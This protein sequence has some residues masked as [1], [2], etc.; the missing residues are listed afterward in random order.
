VAELKST[1]VELQPTVKRIGLDQSEVTILVLPIPSLGAAARLVV[2]AGPFTPGFGGDESNRVQQFISAVVAA[3]DRARLLDELRAANV[4]LQESDKHKSVFLANMSHELRTP[5]NAILGFSELLIDS[6]NGQYPV[7]TR[8]RFLEQINSSGRHLLGLIN[9]ILDLSK[10]EAGQMELRLQVAAVAEVV[11]DVVRTVEPL[12]ANKTIH[13]QVETDGAGDIEADA[14]KLKQMVLNLVSNA[15]KFTPEHGVVTIKASRQK[16]AVEVS[17]ADTGIGI[18]D[19]DRAR[20]FEAFQQLDSGVDRR[21][22]GTGLGLALTRR[23]AR[24]HG[25]DVRVASDVGKGSVFTI[26]LPLH[27]HRESADGQ[28][29]SPVSAGVGDP[30]RPLV[31]IVEDNSAAIELMSRNLERGGFRTVVARTGTEAIASA[32][33][34]QP[35][36]ITL[37]ILLPELDGWEVLTRLKHDPATS[38]IPVVVV[39]VVDN[40]EL[41]MA[42]GALDY[43][44]KPI[45]GAAFLKSLSRFNFRRALGR[46]EFRVLVVDDEPGNLEML[47]GILEPAGFTVIAAAGGREAIEL[48]TQR[49]PDLILLDLIMPDVTGFDVVEALRANQSTH[50]TP[51]MVLTAKDL[52]DADKAQLNGQVS[53]ILNR[54]STGASD[55]LGLL[56]QV[57]TTGVLTI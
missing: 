12:A 40:P 29:A 9:D 46:D 5:L 22:P 20:I 1:S 18:A 30:K 34:L 32:R 24:L 56:R 25:G 7:E 51:I 4:K 38:S 37:D 49:L 19:E 52:T 31:L 54:R 33:R 10:V 55:L 11:D 15:I 39:S 8:T 41:G 17:V 42:L 13:I 2:L 45:D 53:T 14:G 57:A 43:F 47:A 6:S 3:L 35:V 44:V 48:A 23:F 36:A 50:D 16:D 28:L 27:A 21:Q 26:S